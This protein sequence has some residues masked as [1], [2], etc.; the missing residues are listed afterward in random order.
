MYIMNHVKTVNNHSRGPRT[1]RI[2]DFGYI[3]TFADQS[4]RQVGKASNEP[5]Q[6]KLLVMPAAGK[7]SMLTKN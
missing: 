7:S 1:I 2:F 5:R 3:L 4:L 6:S